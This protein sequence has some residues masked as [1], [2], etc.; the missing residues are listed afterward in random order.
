MLA[1]IPQMIANVSAMLAKVPQMIVSIS[2]IAREDRGDDREGPG[3]N[4][5]HL[6][7]CSRRSRR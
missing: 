2:V 1:K 5:E 4:R 7:G 6:G 3:D